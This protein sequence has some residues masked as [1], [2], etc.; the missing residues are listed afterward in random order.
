MI[1]IFLCCREKAYNNKEFKKLFYT[2]FMNIMIVTKLNI[3]KI[4]SCIF[5][6]CV[7]FFYFFKA[8]S[9][10]GRSW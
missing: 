8:V 2:R 6:A 5:K 10:C 7:H 9:T 1:F 4:V 3:V